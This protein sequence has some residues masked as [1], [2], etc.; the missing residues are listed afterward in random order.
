[1]RK[2]LLGF[3]L[4][5]FVVG[6]TTAGSV[7][8]AQFG[9]GLGKNKHNKIEADVAVAATT[10]VGTSSSTK[11]VVDLVCMQTAVAKRDN[12]VIAALDKYH[13]SWKLALET[14]RDALV[15]AWKLTDRTERWKALRKA[16]SEFY[17]QRLEAR[18]VFR[19]ERETAWKTFREE[20]KN[21][22]GKQAY[23]LDFTNHYGDN[24]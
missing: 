20:R 8:A 21:N 14:R 17:K 1:M 23:A 10:T 11:S 4:L 22:C 24:E 13:A 7:Y 5:A 16:W 18:R 19:Q 3:T 12:A 6:L 15:A 2:L 9:L